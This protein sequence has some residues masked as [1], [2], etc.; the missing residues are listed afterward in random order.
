MSLDTLAIIWFGLWGVIWTVYF[1]L[2]GYSLGTGM[3]FPLVTKNRKERNQLQETIGPFWGGNEVW[4]VTAGGATFAAFPAV[5]ATMFS[6][7][8]E[9]MLLLLFA[10]FF[11][12]AGLELMHKDDNPLWQKFFKWAFSISSY[13]IPLLLGVAFSNLYYG[14]L[15]GKNGYEG[16]FFSLLHAYSILGGVVFMAM[17]MT[18][19]ALWVMIKNSGEVVERSYRIVRFSAPIAAGAIAMFF[20]GT[21]NESKIADNFNEYPILFSAPILTLLISVLTIFFTFK[22][23]IKSAFA[24]ACIT[25]FTLSATGFIGLFPNMLV[26]R[27]DEAYSLTLYNSSGSHKNLQLMFI[28]AVVMVPIIIGYQLWSYTLF[29]N[30]INSDEAKGY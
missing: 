9:A 17:F 28:V 4:L 8:Y 15:L 5:Y 16:N 3:V 10:L 29:K 12:G 7:L 21:M 30:K 11:R 6:S 18:S 26:S 2:D 23:K 14:L 25:I 24:S 19:G 22:K 13:A 20:V 1:I 27:I